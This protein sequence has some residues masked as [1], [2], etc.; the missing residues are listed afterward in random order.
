MNYEI[1]GVI[2]QW[3]RVVGGGKIFME[4]V[5]GGWVAKKE[6]NREKRVLKKWKMEASLC[7]V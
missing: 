5:G 2:R 1:S 4:V 3:G 7:L 6:E